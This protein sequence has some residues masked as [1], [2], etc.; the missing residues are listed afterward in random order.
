MCTYEELWLQVRSLH[1]DLQ[2]P[3]NFNAWNYDQHFGT[4]RS[5]HRIRNVTS[6]ISTRLQQLN[7][8]PFQYSMTNDK[9]LNIDKTDC[10]PTR[11][12]NK[13]EQSQ[14]DLY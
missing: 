10:L 6:N 14:R 7:D 5:Y 1:S 8:V 4:R 9:T 11:I 12:E 13:L 2:P 3:C